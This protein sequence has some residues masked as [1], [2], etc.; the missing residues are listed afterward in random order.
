MTKNLQKKLSGLIPRN[1]L[2]SLCW[3]SLSYRNQSIDLDLIG[4]S[5]EMIETSAMKELSSVQQ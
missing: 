3:K 4:P 2:A 5:F 1:P